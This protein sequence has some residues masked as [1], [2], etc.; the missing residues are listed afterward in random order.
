LLIRARGYLVGTGRAAIQEVGDV[1]T[2]EVC[3]ACGY[4]VNG[5]GMCFAC[6]PRALEPVTND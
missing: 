1:K 4:P 5:V 6:R 3:P 2:V